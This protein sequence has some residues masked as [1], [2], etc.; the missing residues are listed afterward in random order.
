MRDSVPA[1]VVRGVISSWMQDVAARRKVTRVD[2]V[3]DAFEHCASEM[4]SELERAIDANRLLTV[5]QYAK[6]RAVDKST[7]R[8]WC[9]SGELQ[10]EKNP[11]GDWMISASAHRKKAG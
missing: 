3:A 9:I 8:R 11:A 4:E 1:E 10:A 5:E 2:P 7:V 6:S